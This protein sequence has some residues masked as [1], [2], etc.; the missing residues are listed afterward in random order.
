MREQSAVRSSLKIESDSKTGLNSSLL[1]A[2]VVQINGSIGPKMNNHQT[3]FSGDNIA[4]FLKDIAN[5]CLVAMESVA[6]AAK[7]RAALG[8]VD[9]GTAMGA[10]NILNDAGGADRSLQHAQEQERKGAYQLSGEPLIARVRTRSERGAEKTY[11]FTRN[12]T[13]TVPGLTLTSYNSGAPVGRLASLEVGDDFQLPS[14]Q[15][16]EVI[17]KGTYKP[18]LSGGIWDGIDNTIAHESFEQISVRSLRAVC[19]DDLL[20]S[21][22]LHDF[23]ADFDEIPGWTPG[24]KR[25][26]L[27]GLGL[28]DQSVMNKVQDEIFRLPINRQVMLEGPPGTGKTTTLIKRLSQKLVLNAEREE[29]YL[30]ITSN[31]LGGTHQT[32]WIMFS[33]TELLEHYLREAFARDNIPASQQRIQTWSNFR[34]DLATRVL[35]LLRSGKRASGFLRDDLARHLSAHALENQP[36]LHATFDKMQRDLYRAEL[37]TA[38]KTL[39]DS[40]EADLRD[41]AVQ[42]QRRLSEGHRQTLLSIFVAVDSLSQDLRNWIAG[43]RTALTEKVDR[44]IE[45]MFRQMDDARKAELRQIISRLNAANSDVDEDED[46]M[47]G[48]DAPPQSTRDQ[49]LRILRGAIRAMAVATWTKRAV[50]RNS[51]YKLL[52]DWLGESAVPAADLALMGRQHALI[53]AVGMV[54][55]TTR[56]YFTRLPQRYRAFRKDAPAPWFL[57]DATEASKISPEELD[58]LVAIHLEG[59]SELLASPRVRGSLTQGNLQVIAPMLDQFRNQVLVDEA[60]DFSPLQLRAMSSLATPGIRSFFACG[61]FNQ[62]LTRHGVSQRAALEW[63]VPGIEFRQVEIAYRQSEELRNFANHIVELSGGDLLETTLEGPRKAEGYAPVVHVSTEG[64]VGQSLWIA[65]RIAEIEGIHNNLPSVAV[66][67]PSERLVE[68]VA[69]EL[70]DALAETNIDVMPCPRGQ[71]LGQERHVRVFAVEH[72]KGLEFEAAFFHSLQELA[73]DTPD[74][75]D[76]FLYVGATRAATFLGLSCADRLPK[77]L[78]TATQGLGQT[79]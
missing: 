29:D 21:T 75:L 71:V 72:I 55:L 12:F 8:N 56:N 9:L 23:M 38:L 11:Y 57:P 76:K 54:T 32:S 73:Q 61:D 45:L 46:E 36:D 7:A 26:A 50:S 25:A 49:L 30:A 10:A 33:P 64:S 52:V 22:A 63:A 67:V 17:E 20:G 35:G 16:V 34:N 41:I 31:S 6:E 4:P 13:L 59:A 18:I 27:S 44:R 40:G 70:R 78:E 28:R 1:R 37:D 15:W 48:T 43:T 39:A 53:S 69:E 14:G 24:P 19:R 62:R 58:L 77:L 65:R 60:T 47:L 3:D 74:L 42:L 66:F 5:E 68:L 2:R 79:W 51:K